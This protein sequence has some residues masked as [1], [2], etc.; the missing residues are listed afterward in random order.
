MNPVV[1]W[2]PYAPVHWIGFAALGC[3]ILRFGW[4]GAA[5]LAGAI[6]YEVVVASVGAGVGFGFPGRY[7]MIV[8]PL[9]AIPMAVA[10]E[11]VR[12]ARLVFLPL[13]AGSLIF[14]GASISDYQ[15]LYPVGDSPR[16]F[17][18]E[19]CRT[20]LPNLD[21]A[22]A[23]DLF[24]PDSRAASSEDG[25]GAGTR[26]RCTGRSGQAGICPRGPYTPL[27]SGTYRANLS[28]GNHRGHGQ[29][30]RRH[31][32][33]YSEARPERCSRNEPVTAADLNPRRLTNITMQFTT[34]GGYFT[35]T[36]VYY[37][38]FGTLKA[39]PV[40]VEP[41]YIVA[42]G[43]THF[44]QWPSRL[45]LARGD[46]PGRLVVRPGDEPDEPSP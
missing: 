17:G 30:S 10:I 44:Y 36:R 29:A 8:I 24:H 34:P 15:G 35:E 27:G 6:A 45:P 39:G 40:K 23:T 20:S 31:R 46:A 18:P 9:I 42:H 1:G 22:C 11:A 25:Q 28:A 13:L 21:S 16:I 19:E 43:A 33:M 32:S 37:D 12:P 5:C 14:A 38:G 7:P 41:A 4:R 3:L 26:C 2:I